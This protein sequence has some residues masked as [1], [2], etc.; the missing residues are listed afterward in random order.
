MSSQPHQN[1]LIPKVLLGFQTWLAERAEPF[2]P[3][4]VEEYLKEHPLPKMVDISKL[5]ILWDDPKDDYDAGIRTGIS[6]AMEVFTGEDGYK[7]K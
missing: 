1:P 6:S 5:K 3:G 4:E 7:S 2:Q